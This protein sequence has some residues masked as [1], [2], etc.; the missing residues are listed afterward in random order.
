MSDTDDTG[1]SLKTQIRQAVRSR[2]FWA[3]REVKLLNDPAK[4][5]GPGHVEANTR[6]KEWEARVRLL[7]AAK[8]TLAA[9]RRRR[10]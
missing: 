6:H 8:E 3:N 1:V 7:T 2:N 10:K 5:G 4:S 9:Q